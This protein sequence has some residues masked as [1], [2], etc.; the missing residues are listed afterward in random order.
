MREKAIGLAAALILYS[1]PVQGQDCPAGP[2]DTIPNAGGPRTGDALPWDVGTVSKA[3]SRALDSLRY[4]VAERDKD[5]RRFVTAVM[6]RFS[7]DPMQQV[8]RQYKHPGVVATVT[9]EAK[10]NSTLILVLA[11]TVCA[12]DRP[13]PPGYTASVEDTGR[14]ARVPPLARPTVGSPGRDAR[15][16]A[17]RHRSRR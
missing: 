10:D 4:K 11:R 8:F 14:V 7:D 15:R 3:V 6:H 5:G 12:V 17:R 1:L 13:P 16:G 9:L 2:A